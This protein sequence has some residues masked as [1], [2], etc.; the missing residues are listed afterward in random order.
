MSIVTIHFF[1]HDSL[2]VAMQV[3]VDD[4]LVAMEVF[5]LDNE[6]SLLLCI[7]LCLTHL[8]LCM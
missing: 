1:V 3:F 4:P 8:L 6:L 2:I 5:V 7:C